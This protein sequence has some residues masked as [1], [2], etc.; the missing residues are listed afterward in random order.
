MNLP[1]RLLKRLTG[2]L[3]LG[4]GGVLLGVLLLGL[5]LWVQ[6]T[7]DR[8]APS[9]SA[10]KI[11]APK[12]SAPGTPVPS[13]SIATTSPVQC[14]LRGSSLVGIPWRNQ[15]IQNVAGVELNFNSF[16]PGR[17]YRTALYTYEA[18][19]PLATYSV[20]YETAWPV[21]DKIKDFLKTPE[22]SSLQVSYSPPWVTVVTAVMFAIL[23]LGVGKF[24]LWV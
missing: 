13:A 6:V 17:V 2:G 21:R 8:S 22:Q 5:P 9:I 19:I 12:I 20:A 1:P 7:C 4:L 24:I 10:P 15:T 23:M 3:A 16:R 11:S 18:E 14:R